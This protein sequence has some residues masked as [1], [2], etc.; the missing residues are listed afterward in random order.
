[1]STCKDCFGE[2][3]VYLKPIDEEVTE[4][5]VSSGEKRQIGGDVG[6]RKVDGI[7]DIGGALSSDG[8]D[9]SDLEEDRILDLA[10]G[11]EPNG[12]FYRVGKGRGAIV[13][14]GGRGRDEGGRALVGRGHHRHGRGGVGKVKSG[15]G[16]RET[17][18]IT[19]DLHCWNVILEVKPQGGVFRMNL[20]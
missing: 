13:G 17:G 4:F 5:V 10:G 16:R 14:D 11:L 9:G 2:R 7:K 19:S 20:R 18:S 6:S 12:G 8:G 15:R 1:V 3:I